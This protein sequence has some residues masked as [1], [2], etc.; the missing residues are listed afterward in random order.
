MH[1]YPQSSLVEIIRKGFLATTVLAFA[2]IAQANVHF[3]FSQVDDY[4]IMSSSGTFNTAGLVVFSNPVGW[5]DVGYS[6]HGLGG[7]DIMGSNNSGING[8]DSWFAF[9]PGTDTS[10][11]GPPYGP[12]K[13]SIY[14]WDYTGTRNFASYAGFDSEGH[15][16]AG[17][18]L[19]ASQI[20]NG[21]WTPDQTWT[22][23]GYFSDLGL[24]EG[25]YSISDA[26]TGEII[27]IQ[28]GDGRTTPPIDNGHT[29][30][31]V[32]SVIALLSAT[33]IGVTMLRRRLVT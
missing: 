30:P 10:G 6:D 5:G 9:N 15:I 14:G 19:L 26:L 32:S 7:I 21:V 25:V 11:F 4:V 13:K 22:R 27:T 1:F 17:I 29:V 8:I 16:V 23:G 24:R 28:V 2:A 3:Q 20:V 31:D 18:G 33:L 12:F